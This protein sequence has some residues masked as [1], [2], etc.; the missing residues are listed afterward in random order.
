MSDRFC[1][2][3]TIGGR[4]KRADVPEFLAAVADAGGALEWGEAV[5]VPTNEQELLDGL[6]DGR[7]VL[8]DDQA[9]YGEFTEL[10][11]ACRTLG[12]AY[13]RHSEGKYEYDPEVVDWH[14]EMTEPLVRMGSNAAAGNTFVRAESVRQAIACLKAGGAKRAL[15]LLRDACPFVPDVPMFE[16]I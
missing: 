9:R 7:L 14:P 5:F 13:R 4:L 1:G 3:I 2:R 15:S 10:E 11:E 8:R 6:T 16:I 12:L